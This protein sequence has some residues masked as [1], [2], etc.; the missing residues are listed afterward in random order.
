MVLKE[1]PE[2][3]CQ[4]CPAEDTAAEFVT[5]L[6]KGLTSSEAAERLARF[7]PNLVTPKKRTGPLMRF[8]L[9]FHQPLIYIL[10]AAGAVTAAL[11]DWVDSSVIF[12]VVLVNAVV[13]F[14][15]E[16]RAESAIESHMTLMT[17]QAVVLRDGAPHTVPSADLVPGIIALLRGKGFTLAPDDGSIRGVLAL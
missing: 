13:G 14:I 15:Q 12:G 16:S 17:T 5:D 8:L 3:P 7:G 10:I 9:Q 6:E 11:G 1:L 2:K 4:G